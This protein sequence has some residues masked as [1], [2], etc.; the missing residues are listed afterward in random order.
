M[1][2]RCPPKSH[3]FTLLELLVAI[4]ILA[5]LAVFSWRTLDAITRTSDALKISSERIDGLARVFAA[6]ERDVGSASD[7]DLPAA[8]VLRLIAPGGAV[9]YRIDSNQLMRELPGSDSGLL[10]TGVTQMRVDLVRASRL[11]LDNP[12][13]GNSS[14]SGNPANGGSSAG[15]NG[16][17]GSGSNSFINS[18]TSSDSAGQAAGLPLE[19]RVVAV[20][21]ALTLDNG[22]IVTRLLLLNAV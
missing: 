19:Q 1:T 8:G 9:A 5:L 11:K 16:G 12:N 2:M 17:A 22:D 18:G 14:N 6:M 4:S 7:A 13:G 10:A 20:K 21:I 3:G 15:A